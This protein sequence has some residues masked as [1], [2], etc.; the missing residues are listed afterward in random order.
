MNI[1]SSSPAVRSV[2]SAAEAALL[3]HIENTS[4]LDSP[5]KEKMKSL[6]KT[7]VIP[8]ST[9]VPSV[10][11]TPV[12]KIAV[13][14][15]AGCAISI[16]IGGIVLNANKIET[17]DYLQITLATIVGGLAGMIVPTPRDE[18]TLRDEL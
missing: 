10:P 3:E 7:T 5:E 2:V 13:S 4:D 8:K 6:V 16:V 14:S 12:Y 1:T 11:S 17:P 15:L 18:S 9:I